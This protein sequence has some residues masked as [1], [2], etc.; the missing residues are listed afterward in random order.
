[1]LNKYMLPY[2]Q[3]IGSSLVELPVGITFS[4]DKMKG[5]I[6]YAEADK[7]KAKAFI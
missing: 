7:R 6:Y 3:P 5:N 2:V 1:M 4:L